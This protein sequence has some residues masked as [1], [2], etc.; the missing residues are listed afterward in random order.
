VCACVCVC[1]CVYMLCVYMHCECVYVCVCSAHDLIARGFD[2]IK[3]EGPSVP[4][5]LHSNQGPSE[6]MLG[7]QCD[8]LCGGVV[9]VGGGP[10]TAIEVPVVTS[11][12]SSVSSF[13]HIRQL[14]NARVTPLPMLAHV[15]FVHPWWNG[16]P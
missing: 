11:L 15:S 1:A 6:H 3:I 10:V 13:Q 8:Q 2:F 9:V 16:T 7:F 5:S 4:P 12:G 14:T